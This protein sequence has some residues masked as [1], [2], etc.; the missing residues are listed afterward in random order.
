MDWVSFE[1][2]SFSFPMA[3]SMRRYPGEVW[4]LPP[5][6][7]QGGDGKARRHVLLTPCDSSDDIGTLAYASTQ[8]TEARFGA[9]SVL[10]DPRE[11]GVSSGFAKPTYVYA[12]RLAPAASRDFLRMTGHLTAE[13]PMLRRALVHALG[14]GTGTARGGYAEG[15]WRG[16][17]VRLASSR[18]EHIGY[19][20]GVIV[21]DPAYSNHLRY[22]LIIPVE[23]LSE[24][25]ATAGDVEITDGEWVRNLM[26][27]SRG[28]LLAVADVQAVFHPT[29]IESDM[30]IVVDDLTMLQIEAALARLFL[31]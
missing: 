19:D 14:F 3:E 6:A 15:S 11:S 29:D 21:T 28:V 7:A 20:H 8:F 5:E 23:D 26:P 27:N 16:H 12:S 4:I 13:M 30:G 1:V 18:R 17:V 9:A 25:E 10:I 22:Q 2:Q 31:L 24:Y